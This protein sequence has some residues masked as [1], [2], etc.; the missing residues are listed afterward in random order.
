MEKKGGILKNSPIGCEENPTQFISEMLGKIGNAFIS[1]RKRSFA[2][3]LQK[4]G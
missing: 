1:C 4:K 3:W 2:N